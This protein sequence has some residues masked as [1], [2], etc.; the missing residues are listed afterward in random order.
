MINSESTIAAL[1]TSAHPSGIGVVRISGSRSRDIAHEIFRPE[2][3]KSPLENPRLAVFGEIVDPAS[4]KALDCGLCIYMRGPRS[5][6][7]EDVIE[8]H[9]HGSPLI[10]QKVLRIIYGLGAIPA[11][12]GEF[13]KRAY[14]RGKIDLLQA[15]AVGDLISAAS[16][17]ALRVAQEQLAGRF[18]TAL[19]EIGEPLRDV[20]AE[21]EALIDFP[22][23]DIAPESLEKLLLKTTHSEQ[24][25]R[26]LIESYQYGEIIRDGFKVLLCGPPNVGK[27]SLLNTLLGT[28]KA[29]VTD[30]SGTTRDLIEGQLLIGEYHCILCD[31]AGITTTADRVEKLGVELALGKLGWADLVL[32]VVDPSIDATRISELLKVVRPQAKRIWLVLNK[33]DLINRES[34]LGEFGVPLKLVSALNGSGLQALRAELVS[35]IET[36]RGQ[37]EGESVV[38]NER[39]RTALVGALTALQRFRA[40]VADSSPLEV[41]SI[42]IREA[43]T[44]LRAMVGETSTEEILGRIFS[45]FCIGK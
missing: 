15:E 16:E 22:E 30:I 7:G 1:A 44:S 31:S 39:Q 13:T 37:A 28:K 27:S 29:I 4:A 11:E 21:I 6:T 26:K 35:E 38:S 40:G 25:I 17:A 12:P 10:A 23:E 19:S 20:L 18:S 32:V 41:L 36:T 34:G 33:S 3:K 45:K 2:G 5:Y 14:L 8:L 43:L 42:E 9:F 24:R